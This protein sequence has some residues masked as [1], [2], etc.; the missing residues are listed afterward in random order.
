MTRPD[1]IRY[2]ALIADCA[3]NPPATRVARVVDLTERY[4]T[5]FVAD[6]RVRELRRLHAAESARLLAEGDASG[7]YTAFAK[8]CEM[9]VDKAIAEA[10]RQHVR[11]A[12]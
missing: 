11:R 4:E 8:H 9:N 5:V 10:V 1:P 7:D 6:E 3:A 12:A 2:R